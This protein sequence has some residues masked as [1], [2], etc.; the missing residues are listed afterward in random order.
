MRLCVCGSWKS[1]K[2]YHLSLN[3]SECCEPESHLHESTPRRYGRFEKSGP[4][5]VEK[6]RAL[7]EGLAICLW[8]LQKAA[9][10]NFGVFL[11]A[12]INRGNLLEVS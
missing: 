6:T 5:S 2:I 10:K 11:P 12:M 8:F 9:A 3:P 4:Q 1:S 7:V